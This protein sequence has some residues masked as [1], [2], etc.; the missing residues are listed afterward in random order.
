MTNLLPELAHALQPDVEFDS[1][2]VASP[3]RARL[4]SAE[5]PDPPRR[6]GVAVTLARFRPGGGEGI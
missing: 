4:R 1:E 2:L 6:A 3:L 5:R